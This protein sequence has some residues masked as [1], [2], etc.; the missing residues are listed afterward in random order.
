MQQVH[1]A[2]EPLC[3]AQLLLGYDKINTGDCII[4][5]MSGKRGKKF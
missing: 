4:R 5:E 2:V 3:D 1:L